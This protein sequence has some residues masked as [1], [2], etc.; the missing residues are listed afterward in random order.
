MKKLL[1]VLLILTVTGGA[2]AEF[3]I[4]G[5]VLTGVEIVAEKDQDPQIRLHNDDGEGARVYIGG[6]ATSESGN[7]GLNFG[8][9]GDP[10]YLLD[11]VTDFDTTA[12]TVT[13]EEVTPV[14]FD[15][16][17]VWGKFLDD[18]LKVIIGSSTGSAWDTDRWYW[19]D[20]DSLTGI[21]F[22]VTPIG[23]LSFGAA[24]PLPVAGG[25]PADAFKGTVFGVKYGN[26]AFIANTLWKL[27]LTNDS[28]N[29]NFGAVITA[30]PNFT[31]SA[32]GYLNNIGNKPF[33]Q[34]AESAVWSSSPLTVGL[35][36]LEN[37]DISDTDAASDDYTKFAFYV[38]PYVEYQ[39]LDSLNLGFRV[40]FKTGMASDQVN[41]D[42][43]GVSTPDLSYQINVRPYL[44]YTVGSNAT[45]GA[46]YNLKTDKTVVS[47]ADSTLK[48][49]V[50]INFGWSW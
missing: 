22:E 41:V 36:L 40:E 39:I 48:H 34:F 27:D 43:D 16:A 44:A 15:Y 3:T 8:I 45:I 11:V 29:G 5:S 20:W 14:K 6:A 26:D 9:M 19:K 17:R 47:G 46:Y 38:R 18:K 35:W 10:L 31:F 25:L 7:Y 23:G 50:Q 1:V 21:R 12:L 32:E 49:T 28:V 13:S 30:V 24:L 42:G 33:A 37:A 4:T 2:F